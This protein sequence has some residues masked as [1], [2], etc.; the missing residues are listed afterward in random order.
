[1]NTGTLEE[2][3]KK[4][5][6]DP[7]YATLKANM[8]HIAPTFYPNGLPLSG[9]AAAHLPNFHI[10]QHEHLDASQQFSSSLVYYEVGPTLTDEIREPQDYALPVASSTHSLV[11]SQPYEVPV[12]SLHTK[13]CFHPV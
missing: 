1:M 8:R 4:A 5:P 2:D 10:S 7:D 6:A 9:N 11:E 12:A 3:S 13:V